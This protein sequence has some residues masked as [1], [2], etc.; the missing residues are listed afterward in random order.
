MRPGLRSI[1]VAQSHQFTSEETKARTCSVIAVESGGAG[2]IALSPDFQAW[3]SL[4]SPS[5]LPNH[6][7]E[8]MDILDIGSYIW[9]LSEVLPFTAVSFPICL[10]SDWVVSE[11]DIKGAICL[12]NSQSF[13]NGQRS[14]P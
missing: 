5:Q 7:P 4:L 10:P 2:T 12:F 1:T 3:V 11:D 9:D 6:M 14:F 8:K 13:T